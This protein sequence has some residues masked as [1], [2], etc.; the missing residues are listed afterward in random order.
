MAKVKTFADKV[1]KD[2]IDFTTHCPECGESLSM[3][4]LVSSEPSD[5]EGAWKFKERVVGVCKC[6]EKEI[7]G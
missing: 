2:Q 7:M 3:V 1:A 5:K 4:K 6:N